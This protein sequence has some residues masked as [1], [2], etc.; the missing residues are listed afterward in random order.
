MLEIRGRIRVIATRNAANLIAMKY[1]AVT[2]SSSRS[3]F[4]SMSNGVG[5]S[6]FKKL[7]IFS[8]VWRHT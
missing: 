3:E 5:R 4:V 2:T 1:G 7:R 6:G 8:F